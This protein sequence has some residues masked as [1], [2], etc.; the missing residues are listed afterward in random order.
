MWCNRFYPEKYKEHLQ[1]TLDIEPDHAAAREETGLYLWEGKWLKLREYQ[2]ARGFVKYDG[3]W[4]PKEVAER[5]EAG[6][7]LVSGRWVTETKAKRISKPVVTRPSATPGAPPVSDM[8]GVR[9]EP[10]PAVKK[11]IVVPEDLKGLIA[12][13]KKGDHDHRAKAAEEIASRQDGTGI[14][15]QEVPKLLKS[16]EAALKKY[17]KS[18]AKR[19]RKELWS[20]LSDTRKYA[21]AAIFDKGIYPDANHGRSGQPEV[22][23][24]VDAVR[25]LWE[26]PLEYSLKKRGK[27]KKQLEDILDLASVHNK[28]VRP[29]INEK[30]LRIR[31]ENECAELINMRKY[32]SPRGSFEVLKYNEMARTSMDEHERGVLDFTNEYRMMMGLMPFKVKEALVQAARKHS[33]CM[34]E[35]NFFSH[36]CPIHGNLQARGRAEGTRISGENI[37]RGQRSAYQAFYSWYNS[38]GHHRNL[39]GKFRFLGVGVSG[40]YWTQDFL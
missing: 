8:P 28:H 27:L 35:N 3:E 37:A 15:A 33:Q 32:C 12:T 25:L 5:L 13:L 9:L 34:R 26:R 14:L 7:F 30:A 38:S 39:L 17:F 22:D 23:K 21:L 16:K 29:P 20:K 36:H 1:A 18:S 31:M 19:L 40:A 24:R 2:K 6:L 11:I 10:K 4:Y